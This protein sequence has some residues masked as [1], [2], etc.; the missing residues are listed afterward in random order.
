MAD[1]ARTGLLRLSPVHQPDQPFTHCHEAA[2]ELSFRGISVP[3]HTLLLIKLITLKD[4]H[5]R[6]VGCTQ[7]TGPCQA[8]RTVSYYNLINNKRGDQPLFSP[9]A[10][11]RSTS[12][13]ALTSAKATSAWP[14]LTAQ[15]SG[16]WREPRVVLFT[17][18]LA[19]P[20]RRA[21]TT[22]R[23]RRGDERVTAPGAGAAAAAAVAVASA[24]A[25]AGA[26]NEVTGRKMDKTARRERGWN[27]KS[28]N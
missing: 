7:P 3:S 21:I 15:K 5:P 20:L 22:S 9:W 12:P 6:R 16:V 28:R 18:R 8:H 13:P 27:A 14:C 1:Q 4:L 11:A 17:S 25:A 26:Q 10:S 2:R 23:L 24:A 19:R